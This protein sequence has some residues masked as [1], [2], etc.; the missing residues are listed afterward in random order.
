ML[1]SEELKSLKSIHPHTL[2]DKLGLS[3]QSTVRGGMLPATWRGEKHNSV[4]YLQSS[5]GHW[6]WT[7][8][9]T[10]EGGSHIDLIMKQF[11]LNY[12]QAI[13]RLR[14]ICNEDIPAT[15]PINFSFSLPFSKASK[16]CWDIKSMRPCGVSD[17][18][19]LETQRHLDSQTIPF[20]SLKWLTIFHPYKKFSRQCY[21]IKNS[22][23][24]H[25]LFSGYSS[26]HALSFKSCCGKK[27]ISVINRNTRDW[28]VSESL[29]DAMGV[30][31]TSEVGHHRLLE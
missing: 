3:F 8:F 28:V 14:N 16:L 20:N 2:A 21:G 30:L 22:S 24:G 5:Q 25:E 18:H 26:S 12:T 6:Y 13:Y 9:G 7:D 10:G 17:L 4:S 27:D 31:K 23:G 11:G 1:S 29:I 19:V 15:S